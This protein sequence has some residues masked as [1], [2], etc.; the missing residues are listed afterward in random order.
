MEEKGVKSGKKEP[1]YR[2]NAA[3]T[4]AREVFYFNIF[5]IFNLCTL[6]TAVIRYTFQPGTG[7]LMLP[8]T[9]QW[10]RTVRNALQTGTL[11]A[12]AILPWKWHITMDGLPIVQRRA[13]VG[14]CA[15]HHHGASWHWH[16]LAI[17]LLS[18]VTLLTSYTNKILSSRNL[19]TKGKSNAINPSTKRFFFILNPFRWFCWKW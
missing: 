19:S 11:H 18:T 16:P 10:M 14:H 1:M 13:T 2:V 4:T 7:G 3:G 6:H 12:Q 5:N 17:V 9:L 15:T 8:G